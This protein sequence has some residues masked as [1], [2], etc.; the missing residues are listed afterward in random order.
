[1]KLLKAA[2]LYKKTNNVTRALLE[3][4]SDDQVYE[5]VLDYIDSQKEKETEQK[6]LKLESSF[7]NSTISPLKGRT[8]VDDNEKSNSKS[9][10]YTKSSLKSF[11]D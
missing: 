1:M 2:E 4:M 10:A 9:S 11:D 7:R 5:M 8:V 3:N 6:I